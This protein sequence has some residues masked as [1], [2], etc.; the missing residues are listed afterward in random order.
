MKEQELISNWLDIAGYK[1]GSIPIFPRNKKLQ[2]A[3]SLVLEELLEAA[4]AG[5]KSQYQEFLNTAKNVIDNKLSNV[6]N[7]KKEGDVDELRDA[8]A[9]MRVVMGNL[10][11]FAGLREMFDEDFE[12]VMKSNFSKYCKKEEDAK[13]SVRLYAEGIHP[14]KMGKK[15][16]TYYEKVDSFFIIKQKSDGKILKSMHFKE[17]EFKKLSREKFIEYLEEQEKDAGVMSKYYRKMRT[18]SDEDWTY[19][20]PAVDGMMPRLKVLKDKVIYSQLVLSGD[21]EPDKEYSFEEMIKE[22]RS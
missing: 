2:L 14:N 21:S 9:D 4:E 11:H 19:V 20:M 6:E 10:I 17:P 22:M 3:L 12:E 8:C 15:I 16:E 13:E 1:E 7:E 5:S 18:D